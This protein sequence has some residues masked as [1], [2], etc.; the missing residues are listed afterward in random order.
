MKRIILIIL[1]IVLLS[2]FVSAQNDYRQ[3]FDAFTNAAKIK[4]EDYEGQPQPKIAYF[5]N[6][7]RQER[8][9]AWSEPSNRASLTGGGLDIAVTDDD[10]PW[11]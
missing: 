11:N 4:H 3:R 10:L 2:N 5:I 1:S 8:L 7:E 9:P 6:K